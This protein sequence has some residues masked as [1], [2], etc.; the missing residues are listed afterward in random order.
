M[1]A[2]GSDAKRLF[3]RVPDLRTS[4]NWIC[5]PEHNRLVIGLTPADGH[6]IRLHRTEERIPASPDCLKDHLDMV[7][8]INS[9]LIASNN[10]S[11]RRRMR[12][13]FN[14]GKVLEAVHRF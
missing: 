9:S 8:M 11:P 1:F 10:L 6:A 14:E 5:N 13:N 2:T 12:P 4:A 7:D 3:G